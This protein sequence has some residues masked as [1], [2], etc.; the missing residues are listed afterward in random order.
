MIDYENLNKLNKAFEG[1]FKSFLEDFL[2]SGSY[3]LGEQVKE[4]ESEFSSFLDNF[5]I[6]RMRKLNFYRYSYCLFS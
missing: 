5:F 2:K 4:F 3:I 1:E 6:F